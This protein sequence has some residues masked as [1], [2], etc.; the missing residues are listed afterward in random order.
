MRSAI[1][2]LSGTPKS[3]RPRCARCA[4]PRAAALSARQLLRDAKFQLCEQ[5]VVH[6]RLTCN[7]HAAH[8]RRWSVGGAVGDG[9]LVEEIGCARG[10]QREEVEARIA[11]VYANHTGDEA[12]FFPYDKIEKPSVAAQDSSA[13][14]P[15]AA[16]S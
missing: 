3:E 2:T 12:P 6:V 14:A 4:A 13:G 8:L 16:S 5:L 1:K 10:A 7:S 11:E 9:L 15:V